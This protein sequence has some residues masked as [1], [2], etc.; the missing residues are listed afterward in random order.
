MEET[1][2]IVRCRLFDPIHDPAAQDTVCRAFAKIYGD[3]GNKLPSETQ[4]GRYFDRLIRAYPIHPEIFDR[5]YED[6]ITLDGFSQLRGILKFMAKVIARLWKENN[7]DLMVQPGSLP[8]YDGCSRNDLTCYLPPGWE[9]VIERDIDGDRAETTDL[10]NRDQ[11][12][13][14]ISA[15]R[16]V[17][18]TIFFGSAP[19]SVATKTNIRSLDRAHVLLGCLQPGQT[20]SIYI[21]VLAQLVERLHYLNHSSNQDAI[22]FWFDSRSNLRREMENRKHRIDDQTK[23]N[24]IAEV[25]GRMVGNMALFDGI[26]LFVSPAEVPDDSALRL[27]VLPPQPEYS[28]EDPH[29]AFELLQEYLRS[30][31]SQPRYRANRLIFMAADQNVRTLMSD[32]ARSALAWD[33]LVDDEKEGRLDLDPSQ[34][35]Q[36]EKELQ[37]IQEAFPRII[38]ECYRWLLCPEQET[39]TAPLPTITVFSLNTTAGT[40]SS[41]IE[42]TCIENELVLTSWSPIHL[43]TRLKELYWTPKQPA[44]RAITFWEDTLRYLYLPRLRNRDVLTQTIHSGAASRDFFGTAY[45]QSGGEFEGFHLGSG[46][47]QLDKTLLLIEPKAARAYEK[48]YHPI[49]EAVLPVQNSLAFNPSPLSTT[50]SF[51]GTAEVSTVM[52]AQLADQI[53][54]ALAANPQATVRV[55]VEI[56][57]IP[58]ANDRNKKEK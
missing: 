30:Q 6:W 57:T 55:T 26:H 58:P 12:F 35:K 15:A 51:H 27:V 10:E 23:R 56:S 50:T 1:F 19:A 28:R 16:R 47:V 13:G 33:S 8:L 22:R 43:R 29:P 18:R 25:F 21:E 24:K 17:A 20:S 14:Q 53:V 7:R 54:A 39:P 3:E 2:D 5:I 45:G 46:T 11:H 37:T 41:E 9:V 36:A 44:A 49:T 38:R 34:K 40:M 31:G 42:R 32:A 48:A 4:E 52:F